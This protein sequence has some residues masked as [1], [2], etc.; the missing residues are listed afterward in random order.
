M[1]ACFLSGG[2]ASHSSGGTVFLASARALLY[3]VSSSLSASLSASRGGGDVGDCGVNA[4]SFGGA[5]CGDR[6]TKAL[7]VRT[8]MKS[9]FVVGKL[10]GGWSGEVGW[11]FGSGPSSLEEALLGKP[12]DVDGVLN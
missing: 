2:K 12:E 6:G 8:S 5:C 3:M 1:Q 10:G 11:N 7:F 4:T 9:P